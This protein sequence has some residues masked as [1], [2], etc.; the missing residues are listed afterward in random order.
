MNSVLPKFKYNPNAVSLGVIK[1]ENTLCPV[2]KAER[3]YKYDGPFYSLENIEG[4][5]PWC[6]SDGS[7][8]KMFDGEFQDAANCD[9]VEKNEYTDELIHKTPGYV[10]WQQEYWLSHCG[11]YCAIVQYVGWNEIKHLQE[12]LYE[13]IAKICTEFRLTQE[14]FQGRLINEGGLQGYLFECVRCGK[15]RLYADTN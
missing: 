11:D 9:A 13:D 1:K 14:E 7:A 15:H 10:S 12:E 2:C 6:I 3:E 4:I 5:C 8:A